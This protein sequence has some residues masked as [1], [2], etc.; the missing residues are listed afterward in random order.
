MPH[1]AE[2]ANQGR[3]AN[4]AWRP[5]LLATL[6]LVA[7]WAATFH[8]ALAGR[9]VMDHAGC[10]MAGDA[11]YDVPPGP[12]WRW[13]DPSAALEHQPWDRRIFSTFARGEWPLWMPDVGCGAPL[14]G[15]GQSAPLS[16]YKWALLWP[17]QG[18][19]T[20][21][22]MVGRHLLAGLGALAL[23]A[24]LGLSA[25]AGFVAGG[26][27]MLAA[28]FLYQLELPSSLTVQF[29]PWL[30]LVAEWLR[31]APSPRRVAAGGLA[32]AGLGLVGHAEAA[33]TT[34]LG[35]GAV[36]LVAVVA[37][38]ER[39]GRQTLAGLAALGLGALL[40]M[41][42][43]L[44]FLELAANAQSY[45]YTRASDAWTMGWKHM[46]VFAVSHL[47]T[48]LGMAESPDFN[49]HAGLVAAALAPLGLLHQ[50]TR[51]V[52]LPLIAT[53]VACWLMLP[54]YTALP[55]ARFAPNSFYTPPLLALGLALL[56]G[57]GL[58][59]LRRGLPGRAAWALAGGLALTAGAVARY[60]AWSTTRL[61]GDLGDA[62][63]WLVAVAA[64]VG[65][66]AWRPEAR[67]LVAPA[68]AALAGAHLWMGA[69]LTYH[70]SPAFTFPTPPIVAHLQ[71]PGR[72]GRVAGGT[73]ALL[74]DATSVHR[75]ASAE[76]V[77][78]FVLA[79][80]ATFMAALNG[81]TCRPSI[82]HVVVQP[83]F[84][85]GLL[86]VANVRWLA[87][88]TEARGGAWLARLTSEPARF[89]PVVRQPK[90]VLFENRQA[91]PRARV[92]YQAVHVPPDPVQAA[93]AL[94]QE[95]ARWRSQALLEV[96]G[97]GPHGAPLPPDPARIVAE[98]DD[99]VVVAA[100]A[101]QPG[102]LVLAD[103]WYPGWRA[104]LDGQPAAIVP[105]YVAFRAVALPA[106]AHRVV[107]R[108][109]PTSFR[110]GLGLS[111]LGLGI[112][113]VALS[114]RPRRRRGATP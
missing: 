110:L 81:T 94:V 89:H 95:P 15:N 13:H 77:A 68:L 99:E 58:D 75:V 42:V 71:A 51:R 59:A 97:G 6:A 91:L 8:E 47:L 53:G 74:P 111:A 23:A 87:S 98:R 69:R 76:Q 61:L 30:L 80:Y 43:V 45:L 106:G 44:P 54:P 20:T 93:A 24:A 3:P 28:F 31:R 107:F 102:W 63:A 49:A 2:A 38:P 78:P 48:P 17:T 21:A 64:L 39:R 73:T 67:R 92:L 9:A 103:T 65:L 113:L 109:E 66:A 57:A 100:M 37:H 7:L 22:F 29:T 27:F 79:R 62:A 56:G 114:W 83:G 88:A 34:M 50:A 41:V 96:A 82:T 60:Q 19:W 10:I 52:A 104:E 72:E 112:A 11:A 85:A 108:Y 16:P 25:T 26:G 4:P 12:R 86:D 90:A 70:L 101:R 55:M 46:A 105:A 35:V 18:A 40:S 32:V 14:L 84:E 33:V 1:V 36:Y 5:W